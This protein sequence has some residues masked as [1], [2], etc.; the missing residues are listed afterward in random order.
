MPAPG[1]PGCATVLVD[2][3]GPQGQSLASLHG[4]LQ[5]LRSVHGPVLPIELFLV[6]SSQS[7]WSVAQ[8]LGGPVSG[9]LHVGH[10]ALDING[11][12]VDWGDDDKVRDV[13]VG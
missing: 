3:A 8:V 13:A 5:T 12:R 4:G 9:G 10:M 6:N 2:A 7:R 1:E 11:S